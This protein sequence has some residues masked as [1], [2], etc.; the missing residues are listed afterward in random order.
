MS[1]A[2]LRYRIHGMDCPSC[3]QK[4][5]KALSALPG[6]SGVQVFFTSS[7][8]KLSLDETLSHPDDV[9]V[10]GKRLG[11][12]LSLE[13][14][15]QET[16]K[17][18]H[19]HA[20][21][22]SHGHSHSHD[23]GDG[24]WYR[25]EPGIAVLWSGTLLS[26]AF[27]SSFI[28]AEWEQYAY[29]IAAL[30]AV[31]PLVRDVV[32]AGWRGMTSIAS[33]AIV[34][35]V[36]AV[37]IDAAAEGATVIFLFCLGEFLEGFAT[38][39]TRRHIRA[40]A[41]LSPKTAQLRRDD[42]SLE[43]VP[44]DSLQVGQI[45]FAR[46]GERIPA[47]GLI[48]EGTSSVD[49]S[50]LTGESVPVLRQVN[51]QVFAG[52]INTE[53]A[54]AIRVE[55]TATDNTI[56]RIIRMIE[57]AESER[58]PSARFI[59][60]FSRIYTPL[61]VGIAVLIAI[62]PPLAMGGGWYEWVYRS[63][64]LLLIACPC[65]LVISVPA[66]VVAAIGGGARHG[67]LVKGG[68]A[69]EM[70]AGVSTVAFDKTGTL[71]LG[72]FSVT[73][74]LAFEGDE[75]SLL[76]LAASV[77]QGSTHPL[78]QAIVAAASSRSLSLLPVAAARSEAGKYA[79][80]EIEGRRLF[81]GSPRALPETVTRSETMAATL[82]AWEEDGQTA[83]VL[84]EEGRVIGLIALRD[85][86]RPEAGETIALLR[87]LGITPMI[88]T[89]DNA[90]ATAGIAASL[91]AEFQAHL[92][93][94]EKLAAIR[95]LQKNGTVAMIGDGINDAP[96][97]AQADVG[98]AM[99]QGTAIALETAH[100]ALL[101]NDLRGVAGLIRLARAALGIIRQNITASVGI[102]VVFLI[103]TLLGYTHIWMAVLADTGTMLLVTLN[104][105]RLL[106][107]RPVA[108]S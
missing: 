12:R 41:D 17:D 5:E 22:H 53:G 102:K 13:T 10:A 90:R 105:L 100:A 4:L 79:E 97:L 66:A 18:D 26:L 46:P 2:S 80:A 70:L 93:P 83:I 56:A 15:R 44:A 23:S 19:D 103:L 7:S 34:A 71:T 95:A 16:V 85:T 86:I 43:T 45:V 76:K 75:E 49:E 33:L 20:H 25:S 64:T 98:I 9:V 39:T 67:L 63:L 32:R 101:R 81:I 74:L 36:G 72:R 69:L 28:R 27:I 57:E 84:W 87:T 108:K 94:D 106:V 60:R 88:L 58:A 11:Y 68:A 3:A 35:T 48:I 51:D 55:K 1:T 91:N 24:P 65:A 6:A 50:P 89:G 14:P 31:L 104:A 54:L 37:A 40:L 8:A 73:E 82:A 29:S 62:L 47:D 30:L 78:A 77:E 42:G 107:F 38:G 59:D 92:L 52:S 61:V 96:A 21:D 99:G